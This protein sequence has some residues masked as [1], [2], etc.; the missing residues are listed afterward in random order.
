MTVTN[1]P[2][3]EAKSRR[4]RSVKRGR[5][6]WQEVR[7]DPWLFGIFVLVTASLVLF[8]VVPIVMVLVEAA[9]TSGEAG[10]LSRFWELLSSAFV[11]TAFGNSMVLG[12]MSAF[13]STALGFILAYTV[14]RTTIRGRKALHAAALLPMVTPPFVLSIAIVLLFGRSGIISKGIFGI[15][16]SIYGLPSLVLIQTIA[17][18]P[19]AY[20]N[21]RGMLQAQNTSLEE[22]STSLGAGGW[23]TFRRLTLP[24][25]MPSLLSSFLLVFVKAIEDFGNP[26][27]IGGNY[28][29]LAVEAYNQI[30]GRY[31]LQAGALLASMMLMPSLLAYMI[32][33]YW[34][35]KH[36]FVTVTGKAS[37]A[38]VK[39][40]RPKVGI[41]LGVVSAIYVGVVFLFY[42]TVLVMSFVKLAGVDNSLTLDHY[43]VVFTRGMKA[44]KDT[45]LLGAI[46]MPITALLGMLVAFF[47]TRKKFPGKAWLRWSTLLT[48]AAPGAILGIGLVVTF[49]TPPLILTGTAV[50]I[51]I[52]M[53]VRNMQVG[54]EA[55]SNQL[56]QI[57][58]A[59][60]E[61]SAVLGAS[62]ATTLRRITLPLLQ[63]A[64]FTALAYGFT[65]AITS[66]SAVVFLVSA[67]WTLMTITI[68]SNV[69]LA[70]LGLASA[71]GVVLIVIVMV[72]LGA[73]QLALNWNNNRQKTKTTRGKIS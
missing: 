26:L 50:I 40:T 12:F 36:S 32:H 20:M 34:S 25:A 8:G 54:I 9:R 21:I 39:K 73:M 6:S 17:F 13:S 5:G 14:T 59:L 43:N 57:D 18:T 69:Q 30:I 11:W 3:L 61:A 45:L 22:A 28:S 51:V 15:S 7:K 65:R 46:A 16:P 55:G 27:V 4:P 62:N 23:T 29:V 42:G 1:A 72:V 68:L 66:V 71:Y 58:P 10:G 33:Q 64:L 38:T 56:R 48:Y 63:P 35:N 67:N 49:N 37:S 53:V 47:L 2:V 31:D 60:E 19:I 41:P 52:A 44:F 24:L 70:N